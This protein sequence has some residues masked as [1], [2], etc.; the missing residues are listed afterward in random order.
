LRSDIYDRIREFAREPDKIP[1]T[2]I[3]WDSPDLLRRIVEDR[4]VA[5]QLDAA[6]PPEE[7][8]ERYFPPAVNNLAPDQYILSR[9]RPRPRDLIRIAKASVASAINARR[10]TVE[11]R[12]IEVA[13]REYS[14]FAAE[15]LVI[16]SGVGLPGFESVLIEFAGANPRLD[17]T[18]VLRTIERA[19][20]PTG[21]TEQYLDRLV[22]S[23]FL[24]YVINGGDARF[25]DEPTEVPLLDAMARR[26]R[27]EGHSVEFEIHTAFR[28]YLQLADH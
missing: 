13:E 12:D 22:G 8:W 23:G 7:F 15:S 11:A 25:V 28:R 4:Y 21:E 19:G 26:A 18:E 9:I 24:G 10:G 27:E 6:T 14:Q 1:I 2:R 3:K 17:E 20:S 16:E 5:Q